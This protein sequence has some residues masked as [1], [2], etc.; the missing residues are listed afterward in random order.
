MGFFSSGNKKTAR[1]HDLDDEQLIVLYSRHYDP[2]CIG[3]LYERYT[4]LVF[5]VCMKYLHNENDAEDIVMLIFEKL[6][7][8]LRSTRV[9]NFKN[10]L[11]TITR[12]QC[13]MNLRHNRT[14]DRYK[15]INL[16]KLESEVMESGY[17]LH[18]DNEENREESI[19]N[20]EAAISLLNDAQQQCIR[21]F[22]LEEKSYREVSDATG[23][24]M[25]EVKSHLQNGRR[26]LK[27]SLE[28]HLEHE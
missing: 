10:W 23:F 3:V 26:N 6:I 19:G 21:L 14:V 18:H 24:S 11:F 12:N 7:K 20:L 25:K 27:I 5:A 8:E 2:E 9:E 28:K 17:G 16:R 22:Y 4:H 15:E 1:L 13:L